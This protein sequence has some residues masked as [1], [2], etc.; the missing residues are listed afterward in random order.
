MG[1]SELDRSVHRTTEIRRSEARPQVQEMTFHYAWADASG[2]IHREQIDFELTWMFP[3]E[4]VTLFERHG[5]V[6]EALWGDYDGNP[7]TPESSRI[8]ALARKGRPQKR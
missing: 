8:I 7:I 6:I 1:A 5:F 3:R 4:L 2:D